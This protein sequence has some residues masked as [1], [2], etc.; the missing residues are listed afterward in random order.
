MISCAGGIHGPLGRTSGPHAR[1]RRSG[2]T[3]CSCATDAVRWMRWPPRDRIPRDR[4]AQGVLGVNAFK[5]VSG[6]RAA[7]SSATGPSPTRTNSRH[8]VSGALAVAEQPAAEPGRRRGGRRCGYRRRD[9]GAQHADGARLRDGG[10]AGLTGER[11]LQ[12]GAGL[13]R[14]RGPAPGRGLTTGPAVSGRG[15]R[16]DRGP[17]RRGRGRHPGS[18]PGVGSRAVHWPGPSRQ[19]DRA[20]G[21]RPGRLRRPGAGQTVAFCHLPGFGTHS[22]HGPPAAGR[23]RGLPHVDGRARRHPR[24]RRARR[25]PVRAQQRRGAGH[26]GARWPYPGTSRHRL[27]HRRHA[28]GDLA[29][30]AAAARGRHRPRGARRRH[31]HRVRPGHL[32]PELPPRV[33]LGPGQPPRH[34]R[35]GSAGRDGR[36][37]GR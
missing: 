37:R 10:E 3:G 2:G 11:R 19:G 31:H 25:R 20:V 16:V 22:H 26:Q 32:H 1:R 8:G 35:G 14:R 17:A 4:T 24:A 33:R 23:A 28:R 21:L 18:Q 27:P 36:P 34:R 13:G 9:R 29:G 6:R 15:H 30:R 7:T 5:D 12:H